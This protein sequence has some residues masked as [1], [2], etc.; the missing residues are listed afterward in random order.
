[1]GDGSVSRGVVQAGSTHGLW[2]GENCVLTVGVDKRSMEFPP[3][4]EQVLA[5]NNVIQNLARAAKAVLY[6]VE[7]DSDGDACFQ[8]QPVEGIADAIVLLSQLAAAV[9]HELASGTEAGESSNG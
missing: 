3:A 9:Q 6:Q 8:M 1:M 4:Y 2:I 5:I 7:N